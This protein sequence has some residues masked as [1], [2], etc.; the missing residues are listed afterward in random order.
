MLLDFIVWLGHVLPTILALYALL[1]VL[2]IIAHLASNHQSLLARLDPLVWEV[3]LSALFVEAVHT[4]LT[5]LALHCQLV[6]S[7][8]KVDSALQGQV[9]ANY[10]RPT[11]LAPH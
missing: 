7:A 5:L 1:A 8:P 3:L 11:H 10:A 2:A 6:C 9:S 4:T